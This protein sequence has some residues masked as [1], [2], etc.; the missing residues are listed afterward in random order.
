MSKPEVLIFIDWYTPAYRAGGPIRSIANLVGH[1]KESHSF[2]IICSDHDYMDT[3]PLPAPSGQWVEGSMGERIIYL[4]K[5]ERSVAVYKRLIDEVA[6]EVIYING[7][8]SKEFSMRPLRASKEQGVRTIVS[9]RGMLKPSALAVKSVKKRL[10]LTLAKLLGIYK[11]VVFQATDTSEAADIRSSIGS[12]TE[13]LIAPNMPR[14]VDPARDVRKSK[15]KGRLDMVFA[16]RIAEEKNLLFALEVIEGLG[17]AVRLDIYG[18]IYDQA[19]WHGCQELISSLSASCEVHYHGER[20]PDEVM[21]ILAAAD[22]LF[23]PSR[24]ENFGHVILESMIGGTPVLIS[25]NTPWRD[26]ESVK[27]GM[28]LPLGRIE[29]FCSAIDRFAAMSAEEYDEWCASAHRLAVGYCSD[30]KVIRLNKA[31][32]SPHGED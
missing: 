21:D 1:L 7:I 15:P 8:F 2:H 12:G 10:Y 3:S 6:P 20:R 16:G 24:G 17:K 11:G 29:A 26:L 30:P 25:D 19:Y 28:D 4:S 32:F 14:A 31:L 9:A 22:M 27:A 18:A 13:V 5:A 23:L